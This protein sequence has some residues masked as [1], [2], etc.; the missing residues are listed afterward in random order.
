MYEDVAAKPDRYRGSWTKRLRTPFSVSSSWHP[1]FMEIVREQLA[2]AAGFFVGEGTTNYCESNGSRNLKIS[3]PQVERE[4]LDRFATIVGFGKIYGPY[5]ARTAKSRPQFLYHINGFEKCQALI[6]LL[7]FW[8]STAKK[9]QAC[10]ALLAK[11]EFRPRTTKKRILRLV[12]RNGHNDWANWRNQRVC[13]SCRKT[14]LALNSST[15][16]GPRQ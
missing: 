11:K 8:L 7:W 3:I 14:R 10:R 4:P 5:A 2:W 13:R 6:A 16:L 15:A 1:R 12:C 9:Q